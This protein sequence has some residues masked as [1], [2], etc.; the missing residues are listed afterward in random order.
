MG[1]AAWK[2]KPDG[3]LYYRISGWRYTK[4]M[5]IG[6]MIEWTPYHRPDGDGQLIMPG[7]NGPMATIQF[8]NL[9]DGLEDYE[10][11]WVL[12]DELQTMASTAA[13]NEEANALL[14]VPEGLLRSLTEYSEDPNVLREHRRT[15][16]ET[17]VRLK[18]R[19]AAREAGRED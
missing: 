16:A 8:E 1:F 7:I 2:Y 11:L 4:P 13:G 6:P 9:R 5:D 12:R 10:Y 17:I 19:R 14:T 15:I 18:R 3:F